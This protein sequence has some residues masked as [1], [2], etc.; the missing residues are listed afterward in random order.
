ML[1][2]LAETRRHFG[3]R[4]SNVGRHPR[5]RALRRYELTCKRTWHRIFDLLLKTRQKG[6]ELDIATIASI[7]RSDPTVTTDVIHEWGQ[8]VAD[9]M[10]LPDEPDPPIEEPVSPIEANPVSE[11]AP[12]EPNSYVQATS[13]EHRDA[14]KEVR[15][16]TPHV[17]RTAGGRGITSK[18]TKQPAFERMMRGRKTLMNLSPIFGE[19]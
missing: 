18:A 13:P 15:T 12:N 17:E 6:E 4:P 8:F 10:T 1:R 3:R 5:G 19:Q 14:A 11:N 2:R 9:E 16:D 7:R